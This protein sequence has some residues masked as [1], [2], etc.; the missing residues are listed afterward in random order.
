[1]QQDFKKARKSLDEIVL[2]ARKIKDK[3]LPAERRIR[4][5]SVELPKTMLITRL[6]DELL[7]IQRTAMLK[8]SKSGNTTLTKMQGRA[9]FP[10]AVA[11]Y[12]PLRTQDFPFDYTDFY[13][14]SLGFR[15]HSSDEGGI[16]DLLLRAQNPDLPHN[17]KTKLPSIY[18]LE[19]RAGRG[20]VKAQTLKDLQ[21]F[22][23]LKVNKFFEAYLDLLRYIRDRLGDFAEFNVEG[24]EER[25]IPTNLPN[26]PI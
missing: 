7:G 24:L 4:E 22:H 6:Y 23:E 5:S 11:L 17:E 14:G 8:S 25:S 9:I 26:I 16:L 15:Y 3:L 10:F 19:E 1:M 12:M 21:Y 20:P 18:V 13:R 2:K